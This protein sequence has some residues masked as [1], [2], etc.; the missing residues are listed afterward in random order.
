[1]ISFIQPL[2]CVAVQEAVRS[3]ILIVVGKDPLPTELLFQIDNRGLL[4]EEVFGVG[5]A[6]VRCL[7]F[8]ARYQAGL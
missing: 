4:G 8:I 6:Q 5:V 2:C 7:P 3:K 1:M